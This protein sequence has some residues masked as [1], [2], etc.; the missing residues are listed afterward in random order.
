MPAEKGIQIDRKKKMLFSAILLIISLVFLFLIEAFLRL[1]DYGDNYKL[2][3]DVELYGKTY[4]EC[5][6]DYGKKYFN[7]LPYT[8]PYPDLFLKEKPDT[9]FRIFV[10]GS[11]TV[12]GFPYSAGM[13]FSRILEERLRDCYPK[14]R[15]EMV[16]IAITAINSY[17]FRDKID[18]ILAEKPDAV[19]IYAGHNEFYGGLG[20]GSSD[21]FGKVRWMKVLHL[22]LMDLK[23]YQFVR[24]IIF[25]VNKALNESST[26][27][28][29]ETATLMEKSAANRGIEY[30]SKVYLLTHEN[31]EKNMSVIL[32]KAKRKEVP[33]FFSEV[34]SNISDLRPFAS[35]N[36]VEYPPAG[37]VFDKATGFEM[38]GM[39]DEARKNFYYA[40]DLD[41]IRFRAS[42]D[43]NTTI[44]KLALQYN[45]YLVPMQRIFE[46]NSPNGLIGDELLTEHVHPNIDGYFL[47]ADAFFS[48][49]TDSK[50]L[51]KPD[52]LK[53]KSSQWYRQHWGYTALD[54]LAADILI[55]KLKGGWP[56]KPDSIV[57]TFIR[58]YQPQSFIDSIAYQAVRYD[59]I[60]MASA[61]KTLAKYYLV[62][63]RPDKAIDEYEAVI[64]SE[65]FQINYLLEL[66]DILFDLKK[67]NDAIAVYQEALQLN[68]DSYALSR[69]GEGFLMISDYL[70]ALPYLEEIHRRDA[71][72]RKTKVIC[73]LYA[74]YTG[75]GKTAQAEQ[76][77]KKY[78][79]I[80]DESVIDSSKQE[81]VLRI[82]A[83]VRKLI[84]QA[85]KLLQKGA[86]D[87]AYELLMQANKIN[88]TS[89]ANRFLG[90]ILLV[91]K[92]KMALFYL[93]KVYPDY[94]ADAEYLNT[95]CYA[96]IQ[97]D[98]YN[99]AARV[100]PELKKL[101]PGNPNI[102]NYERALERN[103]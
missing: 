3:R 23:I 25:G 42:E 50:L 31:Y 63:N 59:D 24:S 53:L 5:N 90:D 78:H 16:N 86:I 97:F 36:T 55:R 87:N 48:S 2:F 79:K 70:S 4:R 54:S 34:V 62:N 96:C 82:P 41:G 102:P 13:R 30:K 100:L 27:K 38:K 33:V 103:N 37:E 20:I 21:A 61:H 35:L 51:G 10:L 39:L 84:E 17:T 91:K 1:I 26:Q 94:K 95:L 40:K 101:S 69:I 57:N 81:I 11:S 98:D 29:A 7:F 58:N 45:A 72:F 80:I 99:Y 6:P 88:E 64:V 32:K 46:K 52:T 15:I 56:F 47:M 75:S 93:K 76:F 60:S 89:L 74:A 18:D 68:R 77:Y 14:K 43:I 44:N 19:I 49:L 65:P 71:E 8:S 12:Y 73:Q 85:V 22:E 67:Y 9:C 28:F 83:D 66:G 92:N